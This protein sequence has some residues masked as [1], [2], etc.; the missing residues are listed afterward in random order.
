MLQKVIYMATYSWSLPN[1]TYI[2][3]Y[4]TTPSISKKQNNNVTTT[5][6]HKIIH[7]HNNGLRY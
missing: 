5:H 1:D 7:I 6:Q 4:M 2:L 3:L